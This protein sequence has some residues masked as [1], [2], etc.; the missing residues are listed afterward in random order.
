MTN[1]R[2]L[3]MLF[4]MIVLAFVFNYAWGSHLRMIGQRNGATSKRKSL[5]RVGLEDVLNLL[6]YSVPP[7]RLMRQRRSAFW[8]WLALRK[9]ND[10]SLV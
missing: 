2:K 5:F 6:D 3:K 10:I 9:F 8:T 1:H 4:S 7:D